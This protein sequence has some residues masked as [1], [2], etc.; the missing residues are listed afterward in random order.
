L[1]KLGKSFEVDTVKGKLLYNFINKSNVDINNIITLPSIALKIFLT[2][3]YNNELALITSSKL[4]DYIRKSYY[5]GVTEVYKPIGQNLY[6]YDV[7]SLYPFALLNPLPGLNC[8]YGKFKDNNL[9][10]LF[11]FFICKITT[12]KQYLGVV[13][14]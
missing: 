2:K 8:G 3:Y 12:N 7:N 1:D 13:T 5:G 10:V 4:E 6:Y 14:I 11:G 9:N